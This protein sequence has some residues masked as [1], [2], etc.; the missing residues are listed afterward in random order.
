MINRRLAGVQRFDGVLGDGRVE[1]IDGDLD[2]YAAWLRGRGGKPA[3]PGAGTS[4][5]PPASSRR[6]SVAAR[7]A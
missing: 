2:D 1:A 6:E 5:S 4:T 3:E 7:R